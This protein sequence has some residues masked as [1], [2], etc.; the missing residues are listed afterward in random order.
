MPFSVATSAT[1]PRR[2]TVAEDCDPP[3]SAS[4]RR[5]CDPPA[6]ASGRRGLRPSHD[7]WRWRPRHRI[8][9]PAAATSCVGNWQ[10]SRQARPSRAMHDGEG[11]PL[12]RPLARLSSFGGYV[13][14][15][16]Y[17]LPTANYQ[18]S[19]ILYQ[20]HF[21]TSTRPF[22]RR[23]RRRYYTAIFHDG[24]AP[25]L[26]EGR[27]PARPRFLRCVVLCA[28]P[29]GQSLAIRPRAGVFGG[30]SRPPRRGSWRRAWRRWR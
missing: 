2:P 5:D 13:A 27:A 11:A 14:T 21:Y 7:T 18:L 9:L 23:G 17:Q 3:A 1:L 19:T 20:L 25:S 6:S 28:A 16:H 26:R 29:A 8:C 30:R 22:R 12:L 24:E 15:T 10:R 4:G